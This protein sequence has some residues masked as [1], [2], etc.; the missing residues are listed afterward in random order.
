MNRRKK[1]IIVGGGFGGLTLAQSIRRADLDI[2][3]IDKQNHHL[4]QPL[5]YQVATAALSPADIAMPLREIFKKDQNIT[6]LMGE[7]VEVNKEKKEIKLANEEVLSFDYLVLA[8]GAKHSYFGK[9]EWEKF[10]PGL[11]TLKDAINIRENILISFEKAERINDIEKAAKYLNFVIIGGGPTG[12]EMAGAI[13]EIANETMFKNFR[14]I[15]PEK[16]QIYLLE[17]LPRILPV[18]PEKLSLRAKKD[19]QKMGVKVLNDKMV[20]SITEDGVQVG[21]QFIPSTNIIWAAGNQA[22]ALLKTLQIELDRQG[23]AIVGPDLSIPSHPDIFVIGDAACALDKNQKPY[24]GIAPVAMQQARYLAK[25]LKKQ[26]AHSNRPAFSYFDKGSMAT[27]GKAKAVATSFGINF[28]GI[29]AWLAWCFLH[30]FYLIGFKN[31]VSVMLQW[32]FHY[33]TGSRGARI[34]YRS[35]DQ[36]LKNSQN[37][38]S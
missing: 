19:L 28:G 13:A 12:V 6:V 11:K 32:F 3:I 23:R 16:S 24:P 5:L 10:A 15:Q 34:V 18:Y 21:D 8:V 2:I 17:G 30:I 22:S 20:T 26:L 29:F 31:R 27:I 14:N 25:I 7:V 1:L 9:P 38:H 4:F 33:L 36:E 37:S 35:I